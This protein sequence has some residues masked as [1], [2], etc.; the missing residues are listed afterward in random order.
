MTF[1]D[2]G[3]HAL[4]GIDEPVRVF[5]VRQRRRVM[6][7]EIRYVHSADGTTIAYW[8]MGRGPAARLIVRGI[9]N[10][11]GFEADSPTL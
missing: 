11:S 1:E 2:R 4:K 9:G 5:A 8:T 6:D 7:S 3:E 10:W